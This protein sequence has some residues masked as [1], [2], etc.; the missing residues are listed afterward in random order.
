MEAITIQEAYEILDE[1]DRDEKHPARHPEVT[2]K[3]IHNEKG[4]TIIH[5]VG[6]WIDDEWSIQKV[7]NLRLYIGYA[8][9]DARSRAEC[10]A[11]K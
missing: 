6:R 2:R 4:E 8:V 3:I 1:L 10:L 7:H 11:A 9:D 5:Y